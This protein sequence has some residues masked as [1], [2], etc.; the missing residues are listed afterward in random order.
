[1]TTTVR[2]QLL[3]ALQQAG[4]Y[5]SNT[6]DAPIALVWTDEAEQW[7]GVVADLREH[8]LIVTLGAYNPDDMQGPAYWIR[9]VITGELLVDGSPGGLPIVYLPGV[10]RSDLRA[11]AEIDPALAPVAGLQHRFEWFGHPNG[12]DWTIT[13]LFANKEAGF[14]L[15]VASDQPTARGLV[16]GIGQLLDVPLAQLGNKHI[17]AD[18]VNG[19]LNPD[20]VRALL[21]YID[22]P[23]RSRASMDASAWAAFTQQARN[24]YAFSPASDG[25][26]RGAH[27]LGQA[28]NGWASVWERFQQNPHDYPNIADRLRAARP[29]ELLPEPASAWPQENEAHEDQLRARLLDLPNL[30]ATPARTEIQ[31]LENQHRERRKWVWSQLGH[32]PLANALE[33]LALVAQL[34]K[35]AVQGG[36]VDAIADRYSEDGWRVD[37]AALNAIAEAP[38]GPAREAVARALDAIYRPWMHDEAVALQLAIGPEANTG[39]YTAADA[40]TVAKGDAV[41]FIDGLRLDIAHRLEARLESIGLHTDLT[42]GFAALPTITQTAKPVLVPIDQTQLAAGEQLDARRAPDGPS[43]GVDVLRSLMATAQIQVLV[44]DDVGDP[45]GTAWTETGEIDRRGHALGVDLVDELD[46]QIGRIA[47]RVRELTVAGWQRVTLVTDHGWLLLPNGLVKNESLPVA[48]TV[49]R[50]GRC[51]RVKPGAHLETP[52]VPWH[53]DNDV[54][55]AVAHGITC[56][57]AGKTY[58]HGGVSPQECVVPRLVVTASATMASTVSLDE[59]IWRGLRLRAVVTGLPDGAHVQLR[60]T[61]GDP[62]SILV[63]HT[64]VTQ[65]S[66]QFTWFVPD[67][68]E[69]ETAHLVV[70]DAD[71]RI[72]LQRTTTVGSNS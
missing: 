29:D 44:G 58:E 57:E 24:D 54:R 30:H 63:E 40:P 34:T 14:G 62:N 52:T 48:V 7:A 17:D 36:T 10:S 70:V 41:V 31:R 68:H 18:Y 25:E 45:S 67:D 33:H 61:V 6:L 26:L 49:K 19:L 23:A 66:G 8:R 55:I 32:A 16:A 9:S 69:D 72:L 3:D 27:L 28:K 38:S 2:Q 39:R 51:A 37:Q 50:K 4:S 47:D 46:N 20:P 22:D 56:F 12:K 71:G 65:A 43:A 13:S 53:W 60:E 21:N 64:D 11:I 59:L 1:M 5:D 15:S 35:P 42:T